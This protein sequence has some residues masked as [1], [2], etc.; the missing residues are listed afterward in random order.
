MRL[1]YEILRVPFAVAILLAAICLGCGGSSPEQ[2]EATTTPVAPPAAS[3]SQGP[4]APAL[5]Q[6]PEQVYRRLVSETDYIDFIFYN[7]TFSMSMDER[8]GIN[9]VLS[10]ISDSPASRRE[11]CQ[12]IGRIFYQAAGEDITSA[13]LYF[14]AGCAYLEFLVDEK[15]AYAAAL[16]EEG[17]AFFNNQFRQLVPNYQNVE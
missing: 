3:P 7:L 5:P 9:L 2:H 12:P 15:P 17:K 6:L 4:L 10:Q 1:L 11:N 13:Q 8:P 14:T 16:T